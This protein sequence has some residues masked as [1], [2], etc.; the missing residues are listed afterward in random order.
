MYQRDPGDTGQSFSTLH[1]LLDN[2]RI[3][4]KLFTEQKKEHSTFIPSI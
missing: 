2:R 3:T 4:E 1:S